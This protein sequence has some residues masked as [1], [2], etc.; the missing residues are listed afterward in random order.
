MKKVSSNLCKLTSAG[1]LRMGEDSGSYSY[2]YIYND[3]LQFAIRNVFIIVKDYPSDI[4][5]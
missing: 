5:G 2:K 1:V 4:L 3:G